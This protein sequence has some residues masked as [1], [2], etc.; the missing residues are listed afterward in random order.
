MTCI[1][2]KGHCRIISVTVLSLMLLLCGC[3]Q[4][5]GRE[6][7]L[8]G[9]QPDAPVISDGGRAIQQGDHIYYLN[10]DNYVRNQDLRLH[11]FRGA[12]CRM[13][14]DGSD[15]QILCDD[16]VSVFNLRGDT[17]WYVAY[18]NKSSHLYSI[19]TDGSNKRLLSVID[20]IFDGGYYAYSS[21]CLYYTFG[22]C[23]Y[24]MSLDGSGKQKLTDY[25]VCNLMADDS[26][27]YFTKY[28][29]QEYGNVCRLFH[30]SAEPEDISRSS[31]YA[32]DVTPSAL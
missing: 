8:S 20:N 4:G 25:R 12:I 24:R 14:V 7:S 17:V 15:R 10:G 11:P 32:V 23:L 27:L 19:K 6:Y 26:C 18:K 5:S 30:D 31:G 1:T 3:N 2:A 22:G 21:K 13:N 28:Q 16:D 9:A 29:N